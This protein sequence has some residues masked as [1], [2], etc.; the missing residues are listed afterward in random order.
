MCV[1]TEVEG[2]VVIV[3]DCFGKF[4]S[5]QFTYNIYFRQKKRKW[6]M[7]TQNLSKAIKLSYI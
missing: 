4:D 7:S 1:C 2:A 5:L 3:S 6:Y